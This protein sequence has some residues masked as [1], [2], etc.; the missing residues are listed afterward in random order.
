MP[1]SSRA[2]NRTIRLARIARRDELQAVPESAICTQ[3]LASAPAGC[4]P[5]VTGLSGL[6]DAAE[7]V[8]RHAD[9]V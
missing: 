6:R 1:K 2:H 7:L 8:R 3:Y 9:D 5:S 4:T